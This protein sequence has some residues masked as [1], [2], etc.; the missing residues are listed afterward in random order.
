MTKE[1]SGGCPADPDGSMDGGH[2][3]KVHGVYS[4][5]HLFSSLYVFA[6]FS[7]SLASFVTSTLQF[8][9]FHPRC[10]LVIHHDKEVLASLLDC[11]LVYLYTSDAGK[12]CRSTELISLWM[13]TI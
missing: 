12:R 7:C 6:R 11:E 5:F 9:I 13:R 4:V 3:W 8:R 2:Q 1:A 10:C